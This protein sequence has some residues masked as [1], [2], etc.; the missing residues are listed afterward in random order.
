VALSL[1]TIYERSPVAVQNVMAT[2]YGY[3]ERRLRNGGQYAQFFA[4]LERQQWLDAR[5]L[6]ELQDAALRK[7][8]QFA[9]TEVPYYRE[10]FARE[11]IRPEHIRT[12]ADLKILPMVDKATVQREGA[13][14]RPDRIRIDSHEK[15]T[16]GTTGRPV[17]YWVSSSAIQFNYATYES[18]FRRWAGV[19]FGD[20]MVSLNGKVVVPVAQTKPPFWRHNLA[21]NQLYVSIYHLS[22]E[23]LPAIVDRMERYAPTVI[24]AYCSAVH[25]VARFM[26]EHGRA[27]QVRPRAVMVS[28]ETLFD[29]Q[30]ADIERAFGCRVFDGYSQGEQVAFISQC[31]MGSMHISPEYGVVE[32]V[33]HDG[34]HE[35]V[36]TGLM[37]Q[38][39]PLLRYRT[40]DTAIPDGG[41]SC[42]CGR[43]LPTIRSL[44]G[45]IDD[46]VVTPEGTTVGPTALGLAFKVIPELC[47]AQIVQSS[48]EAIAVSL[49]VTPKFGP[50]HEAR[51]REELHKRL[52]QRI[53]IDVGY[54]DAI[55]KTVSGKQ[56]LIVVK[57]S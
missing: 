20:R 57:R 9:A 48:P 16:G 28:S 39:M 1:D 30:R 25:R 43:G 21:F 47:E 54:V 26:N 46:M 7:M 29:W 31:P 55:P 40:G 51:V 5:A 14:F 23:N 35:I 41:A 6:Q 15:Q 33:E 32:L 11:K 52:G 45:R 18:R 24:V 50:S 44:V 53:R 56:R 49:V 36:A 12:A 34:M 19:E 13:R 8:V 3:R 17:P 10:L 22:D 2:V 27:G 37:N 42:S 4:D 38:A